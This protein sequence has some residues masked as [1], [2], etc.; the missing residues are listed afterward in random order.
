MSP[1]VG[2]RHVIGGR[3]GVS[4]APRREPAPGHGPGAVHRDRCPG[5]RSDRVPA[6]RAAPGRPV[7]GAAGL[8]RDHDGAA[9]RRPAERL[10][11]RSVVAGA[12]PP[13]RA[14][15]ARSAGPGYAVH[16]PARRDGRLVV[17]GHGVRAPWRGRRHRQGPD[18]AP[19]HGRPPAGRDRHQQPDDRHHRD[20]RRRDLPPARRDRPVRRRTDRA[21]GSSSARASARGSPPGSTSAT[22]AGCSSSSSLYTA[23]QMLAARS[24]WRDARRR[25]RRHDRRP[26]ASRALIARLLVA[27]HVPRRRAARRGRR[28]HGSRAA[29]TH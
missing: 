12:V 27:R 22:C 21:S 2:H 3:G 24:V 4:P 8:R 10:L 25:R 19:R 11:R 13:N 14:S 5:R 6:E 23:F 29:W 18:D 1:R 26:R 9:V 15:S 16:E 20:R 28:P 7:R 17:R